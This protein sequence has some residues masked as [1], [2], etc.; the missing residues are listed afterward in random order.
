[1]VVGSRPCTGIVL[2]F[3]LFMADLGISV[4]SADVLWGEEDVLKISSF[5]SKKNCH[6]SVGECYL[7]EEMDMDP[8]INKGMLATNKY[9]SYDALLPDR[10]PCPKTGNSYYNCGI[11]AEANPYRKSCTMITR[12]ERQTY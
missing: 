1:M 9:I 12:C 7:D 3:L 11:S 2:V 4:G 8:V 6:G 10:V 5:Y